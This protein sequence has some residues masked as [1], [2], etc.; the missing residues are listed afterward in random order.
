MIDADIVISS[1]GCPLTILHG[2]D[3]SR[4]MASRPDRPLFMI[5]IAVPRDISPEVGDLDG[6]FLYDI[7]HL[8]SAIRDNISHREQD[9]ELCRGIIER[10][11]ALMMRP[12][13]TQHLKTLV[14]AG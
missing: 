2:E 11:V 9:L 13:E 1:T 6:V 10:K 5:D 14:V 4:V 7:D 12:R 3:V 8:E